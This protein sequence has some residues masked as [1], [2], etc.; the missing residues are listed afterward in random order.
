MLVIRNRRHVADSSL[1]QVGSPHCRS[2]VSRAILLTAVRRAWCWCWCWLLFAGAGAGCWCGRRLVH[3]RDQAR[4]EYTEDMLRLALNE[5]E[6]ALQ[7]LQGK[8][9][10]ALVI[11]PLALQILQG[12]FPLAL[13]IIPPALQTLQEKVPPALLILPPA[14][15]IRI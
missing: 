11:L 2:V 9:P 8:V 7:I 15:L 12:E 3:H 1:I 13:L 4:Q 6:P 10:L 14:L 5:G